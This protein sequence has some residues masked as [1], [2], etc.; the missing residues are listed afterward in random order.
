MF[1]LFLFGIGA[2]LGALVNWNVY[3]IDSGVASVEFVVGVALL[4]S[5]IVVWKKWEE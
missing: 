5:G 4:G 3:G 1:F 2:V